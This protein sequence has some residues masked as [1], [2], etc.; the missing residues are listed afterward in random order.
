[1]ESE[2]R[3]V[4]EL[5]CMKPSLHMMSVPNSLSADVKFVLRWQGATVVDKAV[6]IAPA[7]ESERL[8]TSVDNV[9]LDSTSTDKPSVCSSQI[10]LCSR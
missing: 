7:D 3:V 4:S 8:A 10:I 2:S 9:S 1:M 5:C 6:T